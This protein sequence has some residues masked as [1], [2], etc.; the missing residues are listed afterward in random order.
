MTSSSNTPPKKVKQ[1]VP[2]RGADKVARIPIKVEPTLKAPR[3]PSW[4]RAKA[5]TGPNVARIKKLL[6]QN[7]HNK[8]SQNRQQADWRYV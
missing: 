2:L 1:G 5:P 7:K 8:A 6:R 4:I 3:K